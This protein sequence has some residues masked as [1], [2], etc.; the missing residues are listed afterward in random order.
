MSAVSTNDKA[1][2]LTLKKRLSEPDRDLM[3]IIDSLSSINM[4]KQLLK[5]TM[6]GKALNKAANADE[7]TPRAKKAAKNLMGAWKKKIDYKPSSGHHHSHPKSVSSAESAMENSSKPVNGQPTADASTTDGSCSSSSGN[8][9]LTSVMEVARCGDP[10]RDKIRNLL[11]KALRPRRNPEEAEPAVRA[12]E[13]EEECHSKLSEREYLSQIRSIKYNL[14]DSSNPD[15]QWKVLVGLF[16]RDKYSTLTSEDM[17][18]EAKNQHRANAAKAALEE[19]Q[20]DWAMRHGAIQKSG[21]FQCGKCRKSQTTYFQMQ[22]RSSDEPMTTF[23][24]CLNCGNKWKF[25]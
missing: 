9:D 4:D 14:T 23:V 16:P 5:E 21:M 17:A 12:V 6:I 3:A 7:T 11:F 13:I 2:V 18:S 1:T 8:T 25:C 19:C 10:K 20:S 24:T 22:T 15:F